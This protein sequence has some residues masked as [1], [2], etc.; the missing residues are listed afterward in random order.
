M[1]KKFSFSL[2]DSS[3]KI[4]FFS[5]SDFSQCAILLH[6]KCRAEPLL[7]GCDDS[8]QLIAID[9]YDHS[10]TFN[11]PAAGAVVFIKGSEDSQPLFDRAAALWTSATFDIPAYVSSGSLADPEFASEVAGKLLDALHLELVQVS[12]DAV[13]LDR[14]IATLR[15]RVENY[16]MEL[17]EFK[18][19]EHLSSQLPV[20]TFER[21]GA[22]SYWDMGKEPTGSQL[23]P[24][25]GN[26]IRA[27]SIEFKDNS[28]LSSGR[29]IAS[30]RAREDG[31]I[32]Q[33]WVVKFKGE[34]SWV[35]LAVEKSIPYKYR[36]VEL[37]LIWEGDPDASPQVAIASAS[38]D[39]EAFLTTSGTTPRREMLAMRIWTGASFSKKDY[40]HYIVFP[41]KLE[42][43]TSE[44]QVAVK[45]P[46]NLLTNAKKI[47]EREFKW[48]WFRSEDNSMFLH[49]TPE[50]P[51]I[52]RVDL[53]LLSPIRGVSAE[54]TVPNTKSPIIRFAIYAAC[55]E[56]DMD[57][58]N[59]LI[60]GDVLETDKLITAS[61]WHDVEPG[62][63]RLT[64]VAFSKAENN[65]K[66]Y[67]L[68]TTYTKN[69]S[70]AH[71]WFKN[72]KYIL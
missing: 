10:H 33:N 14:Q 71:A 16:R 4:F 58:L 1:D 21:L 19:N 57:F 31:S 56:L 42:E 35:I 13:R 68:T 17:S 6:S 61:G 72:L 15:E 60:A 65:I 3:S 66:L 59:R 50:G 34:S 11:A 24:Y 67:L 18:L 69:V 64:N 54:L 55:E 20:M 49:P 28:F 25:A 7:V 26:I 45:F 70:F 2:F 5:Q 29:L 12:A 9:Q 47:V 23:L 27:I 8:D 51:T 63:R 46:A 62:T 39:Q 37:V 32:L 48:A 52:A 44:Q 36:Y 22:G 53:K 38:G 30:L 41:S 40:E 43:L